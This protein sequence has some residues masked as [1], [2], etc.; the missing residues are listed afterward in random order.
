MSEIVGDVPFL[1][2]VAAQIKEGGSFEQDLSPQD[3]VGIMTELADE[4]LSSQDSVKASIP[5]IEIHIKNQQGTLR[6][7][8][9]IEEPIEAKIKFNLRFGNSSQPQK[10]ES[11]I[12][13]VE[14]KTTKI[15][16]LND[17]KALNIKE[18]IEKPS[19]SPNQTLL[20]ALDKQLG[21]RGINL[22]SIGLN[23]GKETLK[24]NLQGSSK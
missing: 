19:R 18:K 16:H 22:S 15:S 8:I 20:A 23:L 14:E 4:L 9:N 6:G 2:Q 12:L 24:I 5:P 21:P 11:L 7:M 17:L 13:N 10:L 1:D 3:L